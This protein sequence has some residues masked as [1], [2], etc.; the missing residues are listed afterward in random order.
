[1]S[2]NKKKIVIITGA[3]SGLGWE[4]ALQLDQIL[5]RTDEIWLI[6]RRKERLVRLA[7]QLDIPSRTIAL[8]VTK[9]EELLALKKLL[10]IEEVS[11]R[12]L[13][14]C[15]GFGLM[16]QFADLNIEEQVNMLEV[17][18]K[19]LVRMTHHCLP[20]MCRNSRIIQLASSAA[21]LPQKNFAVYA[22][23]KA[24]VLSFS[25]ALG[26]E[27][28]KKQIWVTAVCPGPV[29]T[30]FFDIAEK[31]G[32]SLA[33]KRLTM[34]S[35]ERVVREALAASGKRKEVSVCSLPIQA[36]QVLSKTVP[37]SWI[38]GLMSLLK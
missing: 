35:A 17:N 29:D 8:D 7:R 15:A 9:A 18:C 4:F 34:V 24:F 28:K 1:M 10:E 13:I 30:E 21:F 16:G 25:R 14:N 20:Y 27:L 38:M 32:S 12:M 22:A 19:A 5:H 26:E 6:A 31:Y 23:S 11:I 36:F 3:S 37:H 33:V 2:G